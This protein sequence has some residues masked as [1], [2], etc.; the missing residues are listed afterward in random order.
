MVAMVVFQEGERRRRRRRETNAT[1][2]EA[3]ATEDEDGLLCSSVGWGV[4]SPLFLSA[5][6]LACPSR[7]SL[8]CVADLKPVLA[9]GAPSGLLLGLRV[10]P[11]ERERRGRRE[12]VKNEATERKRE[13]EKEKRQ[14]REGEEQ[15]QKN[16]Q[17]WHGQSTV[18]H[19][20]NWG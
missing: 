10:F 1:V 6:V 2:T 19:L 9:S 15:E 20:F 13:R 11:R 3:V 16:K 14:A 17:G 4:A 5:A 12:E 7:C 8:S 18:G